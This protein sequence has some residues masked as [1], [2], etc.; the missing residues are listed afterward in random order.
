MKKCA[1][2]I[3][4]NKTYELPPLSSPQEN[5]KKMN[6]WAVKQG[7]ETTL[8][9]DDK[10]PINHSE[11]LNAVDSYVKAFDY[12][13]MII[14]FSGHGYLAGPGQEVWTLSDAMAN[15][16]QTIGLLESMI[17]SR[18]TTLKN[19]VF[20]S[21]ACR[22]PPNTISFAGNGGQSIFKTN[23]APASVMKV[24]VFYASLPASPSYEILSSSGTY[25][26]LY[27][28]CLLEGLNGAVP[29]IITTL[30]VGTKATNVVF[31]YELNEYLQVAVP[32]RLIDLGSFKEQQPSGD[33]T[34]RD[35]IFLSEIKGYE[36]DRSSHARPPEK[37]DE[38]G[39]DLG[40]PRS[41]V[42]KPAVRKEIDR[43][44][45]DIMD[46]LSD[47]NILPGMD[48]NTGLK[49]TGVIPEKIW[50][51]GGEQEIAKDRLSSGIFFESTMERSSTVLIQL[52]DGTGIPFTLIKGYHA[53]A[54]F[55]NERLININ[56]IPS[57][58]NYKRFDYVRLEQE[59]KKQ[60]AEIIAAAQ[61]G[62]FAP[63]EQKLS[64]FANYIRRYK[65]MDPTLGL[66]AAYAYA[67]SGDF[68]QVKSVYSHMAREEEQILFDVTLLNEFTRL[69]GRD[70]GI[71]PQKNDKAFLPLLT[72]GW[73]YMNLSSD[74]NLFELSTTLIPG[75][76][77]SF[78]KK[79][80]EI[81]NVLLKQNL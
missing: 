67:L 65:A 23:S 31:S 34:S 5:A 36:P 27:T 41:F 50:T 71:I 14:Y 54:V 81:L 9:I 73:S 56:Y 80:V 11:I 22:T 62:V 12:E 39:S 46:S 40:L 42:K 55:R 52:S 30:P 51:D 79:G 26:S 68:K 58:F 15:R 13:Q 19:V 43:N 66:F 21:D 38:D 49:I 3:G 60:K 35:P 45:A 10:G 20:I 17:F 64:L 33:I 1:I 29:N 24:D 53:N 63:S 32:K 57:P 76:W 70:I 28:E 4:I 16:S 59:I 44:I 61:F 75:L 25:E 74:D 48:A 77:T 47:S 7:F 6:D 37:P 72:Q 18:F 8:F 78:N 69:G 2:L